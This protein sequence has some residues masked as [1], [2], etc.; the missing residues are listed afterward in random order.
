MQR[1]IAATHIDLFSLMSP[2]AATPPPFCTDLLGL[3][4]TN[5]TLP[6]DGFSRF[7]RN[8]LGSPL[9]GK[10]VGHDDPEVEHRTG[11]FEK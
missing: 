2:Q 6:D 7:Y 4:R 10:A 1:Q 3:H 5:V 11:G 9:V 8:A